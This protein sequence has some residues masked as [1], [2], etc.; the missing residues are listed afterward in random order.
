MTQEEILKKG[1]P[2]EPDYFETEKNNGI[3]LGCT[4]VRQ[5]MFGTRI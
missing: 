4:R 1:E 3:S 2:I 5:R